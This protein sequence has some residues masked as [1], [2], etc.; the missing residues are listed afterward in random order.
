MSKMPSILNGLVNESFRAN[1]RY[2]YNSLVWH[3]LL[4]QIF[5]PIWLVTQLCRVPLKWPTFLWTLVYALTTGLS[6][7]AGKDS[8]GKIWV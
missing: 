8:P 2:L 4:D 5:G 7:T 6:I 3:R 1:V